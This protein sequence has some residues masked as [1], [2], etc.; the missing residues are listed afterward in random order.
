M[1]YLQQIKQITN[2]LVFFGCL[3]SDQDLVIHILSGLPY[4][5][6]PFSTSIGVRS[7]LVTSDE[8]YSLLLSKELILS[9]RH[10]NLVSP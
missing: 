4:E 7:Q 10:L 8:L 5:Y 3:V 6:D 2:N 9:S 1:E